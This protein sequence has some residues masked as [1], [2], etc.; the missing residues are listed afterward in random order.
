MGI[1]MTVQYSRLPPTHTLAAVKRLSGAVPETLTGTK[2][3]T[4]LTKQIK[5]GAAYVQ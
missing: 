2:T 5:P 1:V 4:G 3:G